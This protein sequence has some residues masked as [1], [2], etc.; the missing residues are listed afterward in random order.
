MPPALIAASRSRHPTLVAPVGSADANLCRPIESSRSRLRVPSQQTYAIREPSG[1]QAGPPSVNSGNR[2][3]SPG[4]GSSGWVNSSAPEGLATTTSEARSRSMYASLF[5]SGDQPGTPATGGTRKSSRTSFIQCPEEQ[6]VLVAPGDQIVRGGPD[7]DPG[8]FTDPVE[9][10]VLG[11][12]L[13]YPRLDTSRA[14]RDTSGHRGC[15][16]AQD[17]EQPNL[18]TR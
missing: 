3:L 11:A 9:C 1:A 15:R 13:E 18:G 14:S 8:R 6:A 7:R 4:S 12:N 2:A 17:Q 10:A 16:E 5:P